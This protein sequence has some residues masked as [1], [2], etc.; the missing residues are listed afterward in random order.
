M[1]SFHGQRGA[2]LYFPALFA[3]VATVLWPADVL[4]WVGGSLVGYL[5]IRDR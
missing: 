3:L 4:I 1:R 5:V 2:V